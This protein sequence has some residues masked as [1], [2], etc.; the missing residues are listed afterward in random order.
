MALIK[1]IEPLDFI[2]PQ[3]FRDW[4][5][6]FY[7]DCLDR[8]AKNNDFLNCDGCSQFEP[9]K[10]LDLYDIKMEARLLLAVFYPLLW[11]KGKQGPKD[12]S[13]H[14]NNL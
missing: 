5:C 13:S 10:H 3:P 4:S 1:D 6:K 12:M 2:K 11:A 9:S 14:A 8:A 7:K